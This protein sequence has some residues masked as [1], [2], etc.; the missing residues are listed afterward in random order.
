MIL[1]F[2]NFWIVV[3]LVFLIVFQNEFKKALT[4]VG[5]MRVFR[6]FFPRRE[7]DILD[8]LL[9]AVKLMA[10]DHVGALIVFER[11]NP[12]RSYTGTGTP[13][14]AAVTAELVRTIFTPLAPLHDGALIV[15]GERLVAAGCIL[16]LTDNPELSRELGTRHRAAI[17]VSEETDAVVVVV[18]EE[19]GIISL[20]FDG[21][22]T[23]NLKPEQLRRDLERLLDLYR[24]SASEEPVP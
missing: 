21:R 13:L 16:P 19:T 18:S 4:D 12:L 24:E 8:Q 22:I 10:R 1:I 9:Q 6:P 2:E 15:S 3:V 17:G 11:R 7:I 14:D 20:V 5:Q 23:R